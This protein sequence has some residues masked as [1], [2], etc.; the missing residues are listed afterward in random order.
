MALALARIPLLA[1]TGVAVIRG[2]GQ[3]PTAKTAKEVRSNYAQDAIERLFMV[4][5]DILPTMVQVWLT[6]YWSI[7]IFEPII[8]V[9]LDPSGS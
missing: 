1:T 6:P 9:G 2:I 4:I 5:L 3:R 7:C 8:G